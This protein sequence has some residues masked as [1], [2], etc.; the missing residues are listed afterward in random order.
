[1]EGLTGLPG[2]FTVTV[3]AKP[4]RKGLPQAFRLDIGYEDRILAEAEVRGLSRHEL[5]RWVFLNWLEGTDAA[6]DR[7][8]AGIP[9]GDPRYKD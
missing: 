4:L 8:F 7:R 9:P 5:A 2:V 1:L 3:M 6:P